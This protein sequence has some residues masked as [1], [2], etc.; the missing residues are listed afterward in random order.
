MFLKR[1]YRNTDRSDGNLTWRKLRAFKPALWSL[2]ILYVLVFL[3]VFADFIANEKPLY[4]KVGDRSYYPVLQHF[5]GDS[6]IEELLSGFPG[7]SWKNGAY[8]RVIWAPI[9]YSP[10]TL[11]LANSGFA[12]PFKKQNVP[13][14][15]FHHWLGTNQI[16]NDLLAGLIHGTRTALL[17]GLL[18]MSIATFIGLLLGAMAG[19]FGNRDLQ[20]SVADLSLQT[21]GSLL[22][23][24]WITSSLTYQWQV[25]PVW[26][27]LAIS[28]SLL[29][30]MI[31]T[32][33]IL[34][35]PMKRVP[36]LAR[37]V[38]VP[39]DHLVMRLIEILDAIPT[40]LLLL[41]LLA[42]MDNPGIFAVMAVIGLVN[43][44]GIARFT[45]AEMLKIRQLE[46][47]EAGRA[48]GYSKWRL[49]FRHALPNAIGPAL[50]SVAFGI[51]GAIL[52]E[53]TL[54][55]I[56]IGVPADQVT[57]G[58]QLF[59]ARSATKAW[60]L[61]FFPG[62]AIFLTITVFNLLG[63]GLTNAMERSE[64]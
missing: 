2:R 17:I 49:L 21:G 36:I 54:S 39:I 31:M 40:L 3:A 23:L 53:A 10:G 42:I 5:R 46:Y 61:A 6:S 58:R 38:Y 56:G 50:V 64:Q 33:R 22:V 19:Y 9:P 1:K 26:Q 15:H 28:A 13:S 29:G 51:A 62:M 12:S 25:Q 32:M 63:E 52:A 16:G 7:R 20:T 24:F 11:D 4:C 14:P 55:F 60:W 34:A 41:V 44:T 45:R 43:W 30:L 8:Q 18:A 47:I 59:E 37:R 48:M 35:R 57:W 27:N